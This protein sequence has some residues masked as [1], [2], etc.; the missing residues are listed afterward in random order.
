MAQTQLFVFAVSAL[1]KG[2]SDKNQTPLKSVDTNIERNK[3]RQNKENDPG[4]YMFEL[5][6]ELLTPIWYCARL[7]FKLLYYLMDPDSH[8]YLIR[9]L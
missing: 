2:E 7:C 1:L 4:L 5:T 8:K 3:N 9:N 6:V